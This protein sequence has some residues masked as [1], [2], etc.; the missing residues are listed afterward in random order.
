MTRKVSIRERPLMA[1]MQSVTPVVGW[2]RTYRSP[3]PKLGRGAASE[4]G[5]AGAGG[6]GISRMRRAE[7]ANVAASTTNAVATSTAE[8][9]V[10]PTRPPSAVIADQVTLNSV[11]AVTRSP[12]STR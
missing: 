12:P 6:G 3:S 8:R 7:A 5:A 1:L 9:I 2:A 10:A 4:L 11:E